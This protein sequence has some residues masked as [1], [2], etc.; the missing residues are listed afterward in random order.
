MLNYKKLSKIGMRN[1]NSKRKKSKTR[2]PKPVFKI[3]DHK[4]GDKKCIQT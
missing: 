2:G 3:E 1:H 4:I